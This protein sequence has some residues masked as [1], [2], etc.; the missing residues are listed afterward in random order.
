MFEWVRA[1][2]HEQGGQSQI[3]A[4]GVPGFASQLLIGG[5]VPRTGDPKR[6]AELQRQLFHELGRERVF[7]DLEAWLSSK[8]PPPQ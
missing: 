3:R 4:S 8:F 7:G 5:M 1:P 2:K 6:D